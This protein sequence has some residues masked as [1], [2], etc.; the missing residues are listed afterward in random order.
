ME[1]NVLQPNVGGTQLVVATADARPGIDPLLVS[2]I[3][4]LLLELLDRIKRVYAS[5]VREYQGEVLNE[6]E[7]LFQEYQLFVLEAFTQLHLGSNP[8][9]TEPFLWARQHALQRVA[10][11]RTSAAQPSTGLAQPVARPR[12]P[13]AARNLPHV[14]ILPES[15]GPDH[16]LTLIPSGSN[17]F[18]W[19]R[20]PEGE[21]GIRL[22][23]HEA[24]FGLRLSGILQPGT[25]DALRRFAQP[26]MARHKR[27]RWVF[28]S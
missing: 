9:D 19:I 17:A 21:L 27:E 25:E 26:T 10:L 18:G 23:S 3:D 4:P 12:R 13:M 28:E 7:L 2:E 1:S 8:I 20:T 24:M 11:L 15:A 22:I 14:K 6:I 16:S 5:N